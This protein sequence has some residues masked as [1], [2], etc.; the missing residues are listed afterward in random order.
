M[1]SLKERLRLMEKHVE[2][3]GITIMIVGLGSVG[4]YLLDY[5]VSE[6]DAAIHIVVVG[7]DYTKME[8]NVN[9]VRIAGLIR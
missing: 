7:R 1:K 9:I 6:D 8:K 3:N 5:L 4:T 2:E